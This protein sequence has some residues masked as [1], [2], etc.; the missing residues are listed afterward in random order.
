YYKK[1]NT[2]WNK[3]QL[4]AMEDFIGHFARIDVPDPYVGLNGMG[5][6]SGA[7]WGD[8]LQRLKKG[9]GTRKDSSAGKDELA[10]WEEAIELAD[11][12]TSAVN[13]SL[14][15]ALS[16]GKWWYRIFSSINTQAYRSVEWWTK[17]WSSHKDWGT[18]VIDELNAMIETPGVTEQLIQDDRAEFNGERVTQGNYVRSHTLQALADFY[19]RNFNLYLK[20]P[21]GNM[22]SHGWFPVED[23]GRIVIVYKGKTYTDKEMFDGLKAISDDIKDTGRP[24][25]ANWEAMNLVNSWY[26]DKTTRIKPA[27]ERYNYE[28]IGVAKIQSRLGVRVWATGHNPVNKLKEPF[29]LIDGEYAHANVDKGMAPKFGGEGAY[30]LIGPGGITFRGF[31]SDK[32]NEIED[33][34]DTV[35]PGKPGE[36][37]KVIKNPGMPGKQFLSNIKNGLKRELASIV[38]KST[39]T[40]QQVQAIQDSI[41]YLIARN[42]KRAIDALGSADTANLVKR[43]PG[44]FFIA[45]GDAYRALRKN[46]KAV[47]ADNILDYNQLVGHMLSAK[48]NNSILICEVAR[49]Q[50]KYALSGKEVVAYIK[51]VARRV[52]FNGPIVMHADHMQYDQESFNQLGILKKVYEEKNGAGSFNYKKIDDVQLDNIPLEILQSVQEKLKANLKKEHDDIAKENAVLLAAGF[53]SFAVDGSTICDKFGAKYVADYY[54]AKGTPQEKLVVKLQKEFSLP[55]E[56]GVNFLKA[57]DQKDA[58]LLKETLDHVERNMRALHKS[59][60]EIKRQKDEV[61]RGFA[62]LTKAARENKLEPQSVYTAYDKVMFEIEQAKIAGHIPEEIKNS[63]SEKQK[64]MLIPGSNAEETNFQID[65]INR[66]IKTTPELN[67]LIGR[68]GIEAEIGHVDEEFPNPRRDNKLE[69]QLTNPLAVDVMVLDLLGTFTKEGFEKT[70]LD[71]D[72][73]SKALVE[74]NCALTVT[75]EKL[76]LIGNMDLI[77]SRLKGLSSEQVSKITPVLQQSL[78]ERDGKFTFLVLAFNNGSGHGDKFDKNTLQVMTQVGAISPFISREITERLRMLSD[79]IFEGVSEEKKPGFG[80]AQHGSSKAKEVELTDLVNFSGVVKVNIAT[81]H[82]QIVLNVLSKLD[83]GLSPQELTQYCREHPDELIAGLSENARMKMM[84]FAEDLKS[85]KATEK[86]DMLKDSLFVKFLKGTYAWA[87]K[88]KKISDASTKEDIAEKFAKEFKR[89]FSDMDPVLSEIGRTADLAVQAE[90][91]SQSEAQVKK[92]A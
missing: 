24:L 45:G 13:N 87:K 39:M 31:V 84:R 34:P 47:K 46:G 77:L 10:V 92:E 59:E 83:D 7:W 41:T 79:I 81:I 86:I 54:L 82:Q 1:Y 38:V 2:T 57:D 12:I 37:S 51:E 18:A 74:N 75:R 49:S 71:W 36:A 33:S 62:A 5:K 64:L 72:V 19:R 43:E 27:N 52:G 35:V 15:E 8:L 4:D 23:D 63:L 69:A 73:V 30:V 90:T 68:V 53:T 22:L 29:L 11:T 80:A 85:G 40:R 25:S 17:D 61:G 21:Y 3:E 56:W 6:T 66:V 55:L 60:E 70:G 91:I 78:F 50:T 58:D 44:Q 9:Y 26:A 42:D 16:L 67:W 88:K 32:S 20:D 76:C 48:Q 65:N 14:N 28:K 89:A